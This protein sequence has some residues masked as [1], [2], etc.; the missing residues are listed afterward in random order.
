M[1]R[2][3]MKTMN[4]TFL[5]LVNL[6]GCNKSLV[7]ILVGRKKFRANRWNPT[8]TYSY[9]SISGIHITCIFLFRLHSLMYLF[10]LYSNYLLS[11]YIIHFVI[12]YSS[13]D[14]AIFN[15]KDVNIFQYEILHLSD[16]FCRICVRGVAVICIFYL[17]LL[18]L[19]TLVSNESVIG[20][21]I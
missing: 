6:M 10:I 4:R 3:R 17:L 15:V 9:K 2:M 8:L 16:I 14:R 13:S 5:P 20:T 7:G 1:M 19:P 11:F 18:L 12:I 21:R